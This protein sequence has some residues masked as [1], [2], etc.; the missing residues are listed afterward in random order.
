V[1]RRH[2]QLAT[3]PDAPHQHDPERVRRP[4]LVR[5][6]PRQPRR[7]RVSRR[8]LP[9]GRGDVPPFRSTGPTNSCCPSAPATTA[10]PPAKREAATPRVWSRGRAR[11]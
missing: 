10:W 7:P 5:P 4:L 1:G 11:R 9:R 8:T 6:V 2:A 3:R